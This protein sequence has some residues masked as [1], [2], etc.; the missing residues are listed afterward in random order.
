MSSRQQ[1]KKAQQTYLYGVYPSFVVFIGRRIRIESVGCLD[2]RVPS[3][4]GEKNIKLGA[5]VS[6]KY[7]ALA[8][9]AEARRRGRLDAHLNFPDLHPSDTEIEAWKMNGAHYSMMGSWHKKAS[10]YRGVT[11][12]KGGSFHV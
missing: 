11:V 8:F 12:Q 9:D 4:R 2:T 1:K 6:A 10:Q 3:H 5:F 7:A